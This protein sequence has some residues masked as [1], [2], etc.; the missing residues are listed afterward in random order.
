[1]ASR[2]SPRA[3]RTSDAARRREQLAGPKPVARAEKPV[4]LVVDD[5]PDERSP[6]SRVDAECC[7]LVIER[8]N[9]QPLYRC[10]QR[11]AE[12]DELAWLNRA[13][14]GRHLDRVIGAELDRRDGANHQR[15][16]N[17]KPIA[18]ER[19]VARSAKAAAQ[20]KA[21]GVVCGSFSRTR[22]CAQRTCGSHGF[23]R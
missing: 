13:R 6:R 18:H 12:N 3:R 19:I 23:V 14:C 10:R 17:A 1:M 11:D 4:V 20:L 2:G 8:A 16:A 15:D 21:E 9:A 22:I 5:D 7:R